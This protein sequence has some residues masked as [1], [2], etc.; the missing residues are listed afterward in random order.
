MTSAELDGIGL[1]RHLKPI[2]MGQNPLDRERLYQRIYRCNRKCTLRAIGAVDVALWDIGGKVAGLPIHR[3][4]GSYRDSVPAYAS[5]EV[6]PDAAAY[7]E[8]A[9]G[10]RDDGWTAYKIHPHAIPR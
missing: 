9:C 4:L 7:A 3:L 10:Y 5:S 2:V 6:L 1:I 8:Q